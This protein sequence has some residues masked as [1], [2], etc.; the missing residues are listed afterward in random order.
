VKQAIVALAAPSSHTHT[1]ASLTD[2]PTTLA[3]YGITDAVATQ[4]NS[5]LNTD[6]RNSRG[7]TRLY[8]RDADS[9]FSLQ[10]LWTGAHWHAQGYSGDTLHAGV[11]VAF[12]DSAAYANEAG[13]APAS[14]V[15]A[16]A[17]ASTKPTYTKSE[18]G[19]GN[20]DNTADANKSVS[21]ATTAGSAPA[22]DVSAW[23]KAATKPT[24]TAE[25]IASGTFAS[26]RLSGSYTGITAVGTLSSL[27][28][29]GNATASD[30]VLSS[31]LRLKTNLRP[32][33][34]ALKDLQSVQA[35]RYQ[36]T[37]NQREEVGVVAQEVQTVLPE[38]VVTGADGYLEV[39]YDRLV[40]LLL[41]A[42]KELSAKV[43][44]LEARG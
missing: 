37:R 33:T 26:G 3:L 43:A 19:L 2:K 18:V 14:D 42:V 20:V 15:Y 10:I 24:Y 1:F 32:L 44:E 7:V 34:G 5:S 27:S 36:H 35:Y 23:A 4:Y 31:D 12:A 17:K 13:T 6:S 38:A 8:R 28:V 41:A 9:D 25:E 22:S 11:R 39:A 16:W 40:P 29:S 21:Y 30:F